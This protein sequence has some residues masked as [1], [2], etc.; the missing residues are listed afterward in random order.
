[1]YGCIHKTNSPAVYFQD[2]MA[3]LGS[4]AEQNYPFFRTLYRR[5]PYC[6]RILRLLA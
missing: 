3:P 5:F 4:T 2:F 6:P 1:M